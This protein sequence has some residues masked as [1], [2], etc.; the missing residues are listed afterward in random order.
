LRLQ[1]LG[2]FITEWAEGRAKCEQLLSSRAAA[3]AAAEQLVALALHHGFEGWLVN[4]ENSLARRHVRL[5]LHFM[6]HLTRRMCEAVPHSLVMWWVALPAGQGRALQLLLLAVAGGCGGDVA[7]PPLQ[8]PAHAPPAPPHD[9]R[10]PPA[11]P[12]RGPAPIPP[13]LPPPAQV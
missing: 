12:L 1:V 5:M 11:A 2:T 13:P 3:E 6:R 4:I 10:M 9:G 7:W 8:P